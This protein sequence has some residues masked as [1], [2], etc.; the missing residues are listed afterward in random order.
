MRSILFWIETI[1]MLIGQWV[2]SYLFGLGLMILLW[3]QKKRA[4]NQLSLRPAPSGP[5]RFPHH[6]PSP[7]PALGCSG[8]RK[9]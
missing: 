9:L 5:L 7:F 4:A 1:V 6:A 3:L 8:G 2:A